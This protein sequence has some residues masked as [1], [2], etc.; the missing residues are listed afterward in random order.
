M[1]FQNGH[2]QESD[3][4]RWCRLNWKKGERLWDAY[5]I[6]DF[7]VLSILQQ[8]ERRHIS[9][10]ACTPSHGV[11]PQKVQYRDVAVLPEKAL[12]YHGSTSF[13]GSFT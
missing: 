1:V 4:E 2:I 11:L 9:W 7:V 13:D 10:S 8:G 5:L 6:P 3:A 12:L